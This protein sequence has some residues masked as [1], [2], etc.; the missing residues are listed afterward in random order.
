MPIVIPAYKPDEKLLSLLQ[1]L[2]RLTDRE[3]VVVDDGGGA[4]YRAIFE[5]A[6][7]YGITLLVHSV[8]RGKGAALKTAFSYLKDKNIS[9]PIC[10]A[11]ADGQHLPADILRCLEVSEKNPG[12]LVI[13]GRSFRGD[14]PFRSRFGNAFSRWTFRLLMGQK[15]YDTQTGLRAFSPELLSMMLDIPGDRYEYEM[16]VLCRAASKHIPFLEIEIETVYLEENK[17]SHFNPL[18]DAMRVYGILLRCAAGRLFQVI[19]FS[20]SSIVCFLTDLLL[21][22]ALNTYVF[23]A[24]FDTKARIA[25][26]SLLCARACSSTIN[27]LINRKVVFQSRQSPWKSTL[28]FYLTVLLIFGLNH[29]LNVLFWEILSLPKILSIVCAQIICFPLSFLIQKYFVFSGK[30][31]KKE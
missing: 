7:E 8:N 10:T 26:M 18:R 1:D 19:S 21:Y 17:S 22:W 25:L 2:R 24:V 20:F 3:I 11:D 12:A 27:Y 30:H 5:R 4:A 28:L 9:E 15:V 6:G 29:G 14:V 31:G 16:Q 13:G 23:S